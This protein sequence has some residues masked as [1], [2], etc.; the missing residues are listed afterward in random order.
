MSANNRVSLASLPD[1]LL[2]PILAFLSAFELVKLY[3]SGHRSFISRVQHLAER[4]EL[5]LP[6]WSMFPFARALSLFPNLHDVSVASSATNL[7]SVNAYMDFRDFLPAIPKAVRSLHLGFANDTLPFLFRPTPSSTTSKMVSIGALFPHLTSLSLE[8]SFDSSFVDSKISSAILPSGLTELVTSHPIWI[9]QEDIEKLPR[10]LLRLSI[11]LWSG[12]KSVEKFSLPPGLTHLHLHRFHDPKQLDLLPNTLKHLSTTFADI[13]AEW[14]WAKLP[15]KLE[16]FEVSE[17]M[18]LTDAM[19]FGL[20]ST[21][22]FLSLD[23]E[24]HALVGSK[25]W[26]ALPKLLSHLEVVGR[27]S[28]EDISKMIKHL[29]PSV[30]KLDLNVALTRLIPTNMFCKLPRRM[31]NFAVEALVTEGNDDDDDNE[32]NY[33]GEEYEGAPTVTALEHLPKYLE[34]LIWNLPAKLIPISTFASLQSLKLEKHIASKND[35]ILIGGIA[36][37]TSLH[38]KEEVI[39]LCFLNDADFRL[40]H[41]FV[42]HLSLAPLSASQFGDSTTTSSSSSH[43]AYG[44][45]GDESKLDFS[46]PSLSSLQ[47][48]DICLSYKATGREEAMEFHRKQPMASSSRT[49]AMNNKVQLSSIPWIFRLPP[50]LL[51]LKLVIICVDITFNDSIFS[52]PIRTNRLKV[53]IPSEVLDTLP[54]H[55]SSLHITDLSPIE[56]ASLQSLSKR[57]VKLMLSAEPSPLLNDATLETLTETLQLLTLPFSASFEAPHL[58]IQRHFK[59]LTWFHIQDLDPAAAELAILATRQNETYWTSP[60]PTLK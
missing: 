57:L 8:S 43:I 13:G 10:H 5:H 21:L 18:I 45:V 2:R 3:Q 23:I 25:V 37:L 17:L 58:V 27:V 42:G 56:P 30:T 51:C 19:M 48:L 53:R 40:S 55:L 47:T 12:Y 34:K 14:N 29:P 44:S 41:L 35:A 49:V 33:D 60:S 39:H 52:L 15:R 22:H 16:H 1:D 54:K 28:R 32:K 38:L 20:P 26:N 36:T 4:F 24:A 6:L 11:A 59:R 7:V 50:G 31:T 9:M 46:R